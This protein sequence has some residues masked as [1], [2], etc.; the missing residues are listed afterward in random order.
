MP[1]GKAEIADM[2]NLVIDPIGHAKTEYILND[3][4]NHW[5]A[6]ARCNEKLDAS[7]HVWDDGNEVD[8]GTCTSKHTTVFKCTICNEQKK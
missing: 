3:I 5:Y 7:E 8:E 1:E 2:N 6:C 4:D